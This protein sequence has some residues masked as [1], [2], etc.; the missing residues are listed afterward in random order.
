M[1]TNEKDECYGPEK[2]IAAIIKTYLDHLSEVKQNWTIKWRN[3]SFD[4]K[5]DRLTSIV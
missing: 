2:E 1:S 5:A 4:D 3:Q